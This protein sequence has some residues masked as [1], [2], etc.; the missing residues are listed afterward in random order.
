MMFFREKNFLSFS[1][2]KGLSLDDVCLNSEFFWQIPN[3]GYLV[4]SKWR[5]KQD[6]LCRYKLLKIKIILKRRP[7]NNAKSKKEQKSSDSVV[8]TVGEKERDRIIM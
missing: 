6:E 5:V 7:E 3:Y 4:S 8:L 1:I 2:S